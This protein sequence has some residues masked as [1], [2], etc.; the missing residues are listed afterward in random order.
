MAGG[1][2]NYSESYSRYQHGNA[3]YEDYAKY[4]DAM[5]G[6][7]WK[8]ID[9]Y[10]KGED[11]DTKFAGKYQHPAGLSPS[12]QAEYWQKRGATS[13]SAFG[14]AHAAEDAALRS[15]TY[16]GGTDVSPYEGETTFEKW[17]EGSRTTSD[18]GGNGKPK[19]TYPW[20][21]PTNKTNAFHPMLVPDYEAPEAHSMFGAEYQPW[22]QASVDEGYVPENVWNYAPPQLTVGRPQWGENPMGQLSEQPWIDIAN[23]AAAAIAAA[24]EEDEFREGP[25]G[26]RDA[27]DEGRHPLGSIDA[28]DR[29]QG[30]F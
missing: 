25:E 18:D 20:D 24:T 2:K 29:E 21:D 26:N 17:L 14:R 28:S 1:S 3:T 15:G 12:Q 10:N 30:P 6:N 11:V 22:S 5:L 9:A 23:A 7:Y 8:L 13:K 4:V 27:V 19:V 16:K